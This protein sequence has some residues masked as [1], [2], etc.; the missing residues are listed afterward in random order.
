MKV[1]PKKYA[2]GGVVKPASSRRSP[3]PKPTP[4]MVGTGMARKAADA[5]VGRKRSLDDYVD[6]AVTGKPK[7]EY[8]DGGVVKRGKAC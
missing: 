7:K 4:P 2:N 3:P 8:R 1:K 5:I 6:G